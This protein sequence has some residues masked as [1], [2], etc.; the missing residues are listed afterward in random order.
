MT[1]LCSGERVEKYSLRVNA[2]GT[3]D[4]LQAS[5]GLARA[6]CENSK[7]KL[8]LKELEQQL[9]LVMA[10]VSSS[11]VTIHTVG[12]KTVMELEQKI[13]QYCLDGY[14]FSGF[15]LPGE[16]LGAAAIHLARTVS[17]RAERLI[18][19]LSTKEPVEQ[20]LLNYINRLSDY[21]YILSQCELT[22]RMKDCEQ[23][24]RP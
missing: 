3:L 7:V 24:E 4:E 23:R 1:S 21:L 6:A 9:V 8:A 18:W 5:I 22:G 17:R 20:P 15:V 10:E 13:D 19:K 2:Y 11:K 16:R 12:E 14:N